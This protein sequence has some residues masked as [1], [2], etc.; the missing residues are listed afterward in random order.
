MLWLL[1][2]AGCAAAEPAVTNDTEA[3]QWQHIY[4]RLEKLGITNAEKFIK[5]PLGQNLIVHPSFGISWD[6][7]PPPTLTNASGLTGVSSF[8]AS[9]GWNMHTGYIT[10]GYFPESDPNPK[11]IRDLPW[12]VIKDREFPAFTHSGV[13]YVILGGGHHCESGVAYNPNT[14]AFPHEVT[15]FKPLSGHWYVWAIPEDPITL[16]RVYEGGRTSEPGASADGSQP[17]HSE[18]KRAV[19]AAGSHQ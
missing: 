5:S 8:I 7:I 12:E 2:A 18:T 17:V 3:V 13:L 4:D 9:N 16:P 15:G 1:A 10:A 11:P 14:N 6:E 19:R